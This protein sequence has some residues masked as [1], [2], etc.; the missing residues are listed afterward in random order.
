MSKQKPAPKFCVYAVCLSADV[1]ADSKFRK[2][3]PKA[4][5]GSKSFYVGSTV[6]TASERFKVHKE[7]NPEKP[8]LSSRLVKKYGIRLAEDCPVELPSNLASRV[9][10]E[11]AEK[12]VTRSLRRLGHGAW[13][14]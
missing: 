5:E 1:W 2:K 4:T 3:N 12:A 11:K 7:G 9:E 6:L 14:N 13:S 8:Y 10:A